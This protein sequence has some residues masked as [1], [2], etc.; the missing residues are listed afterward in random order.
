MQLLL[1]HGATAVINSVIPVNCPIGEDCCD[2]RTALMMC[3]TVDTVKVLLA[4]GADVH[5]TTDAGDTCIHK[6]AKHNWKAP[7]VVLT[8][9]SWC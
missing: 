8:D 7:Y 9:Q 5:T 3:T 2:S 1:E 4:A 6:A